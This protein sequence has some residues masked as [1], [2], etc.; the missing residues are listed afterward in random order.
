[1]HSESPATLLRIRLA[2]PYCDVHGPTVKLIPPAF[3][4]RFTIGMPFLSGRCSVPPCLNKV[5]NFCFVLSPYL[6]F[7]FESCAVSFLIQNYFS[8]SKLYYFDDGPPP[9]G[10]GGSYRCSAV[11]LILRF[12]CAGPVGKPVCGARAMPLPW[13]VCWRPDHRGASLF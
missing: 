1:M 2:E 10:G 13:P 4:H 6:S 7:Y 8:C 3:S 12:R 11:L 5:V 9:V